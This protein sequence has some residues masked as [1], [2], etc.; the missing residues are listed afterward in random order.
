MEVN[1]VDRLGLLEFLTEANEQS[2]LSEGQ[3]EKDPNF[4]DLIGDAIRPRSNEERAKALL[5][6]E[7]Q[8][9]NSKY[10][11]ENIEVVQLDRDS[12]V[13]KMNR[14]TTPSRTE[15]NPRRPNAQVT[16]RSSENTEEND[17]RRVHRRT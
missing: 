14:P 12:I 2:I 6:V 11:N 1:D 9:N 8:I 17:K 10:R 4:I 13:F 15:E 7:K 16:G 3:E 5:S